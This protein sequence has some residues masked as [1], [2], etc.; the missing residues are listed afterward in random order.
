MVGEGWGNGAERAL[1]WYIPSVGVPGTLV[2]V[3][4]GMRV[5][6]FFSVQFSQRFF[7]WHLPPGHKPSRGTGTR[8]FFRKSNPSLLAPPRERRDAGEILC[9]EFWGRGAG[10]RIGI[11]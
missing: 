11:L 1:G 2:A 3:A 6:H 9:W 5:A 4:S 7:V 8:Q 10:A